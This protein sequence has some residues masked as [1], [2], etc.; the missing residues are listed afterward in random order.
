M[1][2]KKWETRLLGNSIVSTV[3]D[4]STSVFKVHMGVLSDDM[5]KVIPQTSL[6]YEGVIST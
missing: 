4:V 1:K 2:Y 5:R 6:V 3:E